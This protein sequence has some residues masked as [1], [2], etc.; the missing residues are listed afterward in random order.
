MTTAGDTTLARTSRRIYWPG[1]VW[2]AVAAVMV[3]ILLTLLGIGVGVLSFD[4]T[5]DPAMGTWMAFGWWALAGIIAAFIGGWFAGRTNAGDA[6]G[7]MQGLAAWAVSALIVIGATTVAATGA[8]GVLANVAGPVV[9]TVTGSELQQSTQNSQTTGAGT[10]IIAPQ[11]ES[12]RQHLGSMMLATF[13]ALIIG[14]IAGLFGGQI[15]AKPAR[16][17]RRL[18]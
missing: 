18:S 6:S 15:G 2:G 8:A 7:A 12:A 5:S 4:R 17:A 16:S 13:F 10:T 14:A 1:I 9:A 11:T 3:Q